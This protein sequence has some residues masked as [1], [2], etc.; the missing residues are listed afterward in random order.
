M[1][2]QNR[3]QR[4]FTII[5][6]MISLSV[7]AVLLTVGAPA[8]KN[9]FDRQKIKAAGEQLYSDLQLARSEA[10]ARNTS[11]YINVSANGSTSWTYGISDVN[12]CNL[13]IVDPT[14][15]AACTLVVDDGDLSVHGVE[16]AVDTDDKVLRRFTSADHQDITLSLDGFQS[17]TQI[18]FDP[19]N[20]TAI[21]TSGRLRLA[22]AAGLQ[23]LV[24]VTPL[25]QVHLC[26]P[27][28]SVSG[29]ADAAPGDSSEC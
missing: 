3:G 21:G 17:G 19:S 10:I 4:G 1:C 8:M 22:S 9:F 2:I 15:T 18:T 20:G 16:G 7:I 6:L 26:S 28:S 29:Y 25:G 14:N 27:D 12:N 5:E 11:V 24:A 23:L 13:T